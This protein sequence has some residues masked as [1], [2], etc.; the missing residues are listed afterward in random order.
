MTKQLRAEKDPKHIEDIAY[1]RDITRKFPIR[2]DFLHTLA[3]KTLKRSDILSDIQE[4]NAAEW[5]TTLMLVRS[6]LKRAFVNISQM[7]VFAGFY[8]LPIIWSK[9]N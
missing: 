7:K 3:S 9:K 5:F 1:L 8:C 4:G 2:D 6:N